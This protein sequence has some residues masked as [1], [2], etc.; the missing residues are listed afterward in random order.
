MLFVLHLRR[1]LS[2][3]EA[4][5]LDELI[6]DWYSVGVRGGFGGFEEGRMG[7][8]HNM[9]RT[10]MSQSSEV[11]WSLDAG[12]AGHEMFT[13]LSRMLTVQN[14]DSRNQPPAFSHVDVRPGPTD[15]DCE[16]YPAACG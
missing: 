8:M 4:D 15:A 14:E 2:P 6:N 12:T 11:A 13:A 16:R 5:D 1:P 9:G 10:D 7:V 3:R